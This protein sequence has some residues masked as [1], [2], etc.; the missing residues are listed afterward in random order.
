MLLKDDATFCGPWK[1]CRIVKTITSND[2]LVLH[3]KLKV[4]DSTPGNAMRATFL[5][6][7]V[8]RVVVLLPEPEPDSSY[9]KGITLAA[10][11]D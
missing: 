5:E 7:A 10:A 4:G 11:G 3:F 1:L 8:S 6:R 2:G 9:V